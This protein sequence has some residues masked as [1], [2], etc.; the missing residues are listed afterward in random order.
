MRDRSCRLAVVLVA[1]LG[2]LNGCGSGT[3]PA[4]GDSGGAPSQADRPKTIPWGV[5][6]D[7][8]ASGPQ[9]AATQA[10]AFHINFLIDESAGQC[11]PKVPCNVPFIPRSVLYFRGNL[12]V[13]GD[14]SVAGSGTMTFLDMQPCRVLMPDISSCKAAPGSPGTFTVAGTASPIR[15]A[16]GSGRC[17]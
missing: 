3:E 5:P 2:A 14:R 1:A 17:G 9:A 11:S 10:Y 15:P 6:S 8:L 7:G 13:G 12:S 16:P 4:P